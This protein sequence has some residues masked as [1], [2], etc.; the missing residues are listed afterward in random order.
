MSTRDVV[1]EDLSSKTPPIKRARKID[2]THKRKEARL[3]E[4]IKNISP[5]KSSASL[6]PPPLCPLLLIKRWFHDL[7][8]GG[9]GHGHHHNNNCGDNLL[10]IACRYKAPLEVVSLLIQRYPRYLNG[11]NDNGEVPLHVACAYK[12]PFDIVS[13]LAQTG[14]Y[15]SM[16]R[17]C[18]PFGEAPIHVACRERA[19]PKIISLLLETYPLSV[20]LEDSTSNLPIHIACTDYHMEEVSLEVVSLLLEKWPDSVGKVSTMGQTPLSLLCRSERAPM[21]VISMLMKNFAHVISY[22]PDP[23]SRNALHEA[24]QARAPKEVI[25]TLLKKWPRSIRETTPWYKQSPLHLACMSRASDDVLRLLL[26]EYPFALIERDVKGHMPREVEYATFSPNMTELLE[27]VSLLLYNQNDKVMAADVLWYFSQK[28]WW[29][30]VV[31]V[32]N[33]CPTVVQHMDIKDDIF[34]DLLYF[35]GCQSKLLV[36][37]EVIKNNQELFSFAAS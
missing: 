35:I 15:A 34:P 26:R 1:K 19:S 17:K 32:L 5:K 25:S 31:I 11:E 8:K 6:L 16:N 10:H 29:D 22:K 2:A 30:G 20:Q 36:V 4:Q 3:Q 23:W 14:G 21:K 37:W 28:R 33:I 9:G 13:L 24:C 12:A 18:I 7:T 27:C